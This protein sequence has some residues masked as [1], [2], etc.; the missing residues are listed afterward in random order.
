MFDIISVFATAVDLADNNLQTSLNS[1][2]SG[3][4]RDS[5]RI[6][7]IDKLKIQLDG[8]RK[9]MD[10]SFSKSKDL[11]DM[12][13]FLPGV[14]VQKNLSMQGMADLYRMKPDFLKRLIQS[15]ELRVLR[16]SPHDLDPH[17]Y[18]RYMLDNYLS[19]LLQDRDRSQLYYR[20]PELQHISVCRQ[21]LSNV[22][23]LQT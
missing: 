13:R 15:I 1:Y 6:S 8:Y 9:M 2:N 16:P 11:G 20:D 18:H 17:L 5:E 12:F 7:L 10:R 19:G 22:F 4:Y 3:R 21:I 23:D 14:V